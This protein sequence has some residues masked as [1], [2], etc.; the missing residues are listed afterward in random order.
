MIRECPMFSAIAL[1]LREHGPYSGLPDHFEV[2]HSSHPLHHTGWLRSIWPDYQDRAPC[3]SGLLLLSSAVARKHW[4]HCLSVCLCLCTDSSNSCRSV[5]SLSWS[6]WWHGFD[7]NPWDGNC[8]SGGGR[9]YVILRDPSKPLNL[10]GIFITASFE[11]TPV[12]YLT[13]FFLVLCIIFSI[14]FE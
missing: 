10:P 8:G 3:T 4:Q 1:N 6:S 11:K 9:H 13:P 5:S 12:V 14:P 2:L 7:V